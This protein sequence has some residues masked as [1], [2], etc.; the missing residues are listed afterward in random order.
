[1]AP[2]QPPNN[3]KHLTSIHSTSLISSS[4]DAVCDP[5]SHLEPVVDKQ[6]HCSPHVPPQTST[7]TTGNSGNFEHQASYYPTP[8]TGEFV[9]QAAFELPPLRPRA[10]HG[11]EQGESS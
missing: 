4:S 2:L 11:D 1:M 8:Q 10:S 3:L 7:S 9:E 6:H 5:S